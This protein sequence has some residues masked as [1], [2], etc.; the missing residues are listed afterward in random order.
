MLLSILRGT[1]QSHTHNDM[2]PNISTAEAE[3][4][5]SGAPRGALSLEEMFPAEHGHRFHR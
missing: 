4:P 5:W 1:G 3:R 2:A